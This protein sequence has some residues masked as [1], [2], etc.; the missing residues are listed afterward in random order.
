MNQRFFVLLSSVALL[1]FTLYGLRIFMAGNGSI[2]YVI[3]PAALA[4]FSF[5]V[6]FTRR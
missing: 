6:Y 4:V 2:L 3:F 5:Y 1:L